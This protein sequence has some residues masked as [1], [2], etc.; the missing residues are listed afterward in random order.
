MKNRYKVLVALLLLVLVV[1]GCKKEEPIV[2]ETTEPETVEQEAP[3]VEET[4]AE[5]TK[6]EKEVKARSLLSGVETTEELAKQRVVGVMLDNH[7]NARWQ[8]GIREAEIVY[9]IRVEGDFTRYLALYQVTD[10]DV[11]GPVRST[12]SPFI[13]KIMEYNGILVHYGA[14][15]TG[16]EDLIT[17]GINNIDGMA[18]GAPTIY[19]NHSVGKVAPHNAYSGM[20][21]IRSYSK[22][23]GYS[24]EN[25]FKG[26][27]FYEKPT[28]PGGEKVH[29]FTL[30]LRAGNTT[31]YEYQQEDGFYHR[32][33][34]GSLQVD[35]ND[36]E[37]LEVTN[38]IVQYAD[39][40]GSDTGHVY[41][42]DEGEG[43]GV[44]FTRGE[45]VDIIWKKESKS[46]PT[47]YFDKDGKPL[48]LNVGQTFIQVV[49]FGIT[50]ENDDQE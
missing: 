28:A 42:N 47:E 34:D 45:R 21:E 41:I 40:Y 11:I 6:V 35:E 30:Y 27:A 22:Q 1:T 26:F 16:D 32:Y 10:P 3:V 8:A 39:Y 19:R 4:K 15:Y 29:D 44:L 14:S 24:E 48:K 33:K 36:Q 38:I 43:E 18:V 23:V 13:T 31:A 46:S 50:I 12:R 17:Y 5:E 2:E 49:D 25:E 37:P 7:P 20:E 9:E